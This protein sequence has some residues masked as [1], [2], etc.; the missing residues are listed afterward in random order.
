MR[1][2]SRSR[3]LFYARTDTQ[4]YTRTPLPF[5]TFIK[6]YLH[7]SYAFLCI[8]LMS[9]HFQSLDLVLDATLIPQLD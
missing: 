2:N 5:S 3:L 6:S 8:K 4:T 9:F 7:T 1:Q